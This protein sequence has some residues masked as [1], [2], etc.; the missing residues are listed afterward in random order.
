MKMLYT[1]LKQEG[2]KEIWHRF[3]FRCF[4]INSFYVFSLNLSDP[5]PNIPVSENF[6]LKERNFAELATLRKNHH[7]LPSEFF[8]DKIGHEERCFLASF[9]QEL[10][11]IAWISL[12]PSSGFIKMDENSVEMNHI[13][14]LPQFR[15]NKLGSATLSFIA[16]QLKN[17][18]YSSIKLVTHEDNI[19]LIKCIRRCGFKRTGKIIKRWAFLKWPPMIN[20]SS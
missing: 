15:A 18:G 17:E 13:Y 16:G 10:A 7:K 3:C 11:F 6:V 5:L 14:C 2:I 9:H 12:Q 1:V 20:L 19:A 4:K 8:R